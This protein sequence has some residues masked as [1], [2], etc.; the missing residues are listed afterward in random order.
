MFSYAHSHPQQG[1][2]L[3]HILCNMAKD[4]TSLKPQEWEAVNRMVFPIDDQ[5]SV[6]PLYMVRWTRPYISANLFAKQK[7]SANTPISIPAMESPAQLSVSDYSI[8]SKTSVTLSPS[9]HVSFCTYFNA[10]PASYWRRWTHVTTV[11]LSVKASG[12]GTISVCKSNAR[13][14]FSVIKTISYDDLDKQS[15]KTENVVV[16]DI[17][18]EN[19][20]D[21]GFLWIEAEAAPSETLSIHNAEWNVPEQ[22]HRISHQSLFSIAITTCNRPT[23]CLRQLKTIAR[24]AALR[25]HLDTIYCVDQG[26][27]CVDEQTGFKNVCDSL[28]HQLT[29]MHQANLGGSGGFSRG[30]YETV[31]ASRADYVVLLDDDAICEPESLLRAVQFANYTL[32]PYIVGGGMLHLDNR[33][34]L[35]TQGERF[36]TNSMMPAAPHG[37]SYNHDFAEMP[38]RDTPSLHQRANADFNGWWLCLIPT[39]VLQKIGLSMPFFLKYDDV[40]YGLRAKKHHINTISLPGV[41]V[42]HQAWHDKDISRTWEEYFAQR[43]RWICALL[44]TPNRKKQCAL[45]MFY[46]DAHLGVKLLYSGM[47][48]HHMALQD[49]LRGPSYLSDCLQSK[50]TE[51]QQ[52]RKDYPDSTVITDLLACPEAVRDY[53][54]TQQQPISTSKAVLSAIFSRNNGT[55]D[56]IAS[57]A[58]KAKDASWPAFTGVSSA[59]ITTNDGTSVVWARRN[60]RL[61]RHNLF[62][63]CNIVRKLVWKWKNLAAAYQQADLSSMAAWERYFND[64]R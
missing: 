63:C 32:Q 57:L 50:L 58:I 28:G 36:D 26:T 10:F 8:N 33:T 12:K 11:R 5:E 24:E 4:S 34:I 14:L 55:H 64:L 13:G 49:I 61:M 29:Y 9:I 59:L 2:K 20:L 27:D 51:V 40:E 35:Y 52:A 47:A 30:M 6:L 37:A 60:S 21:G 62:T 43:N 42:W 54:E 39:T 19:M 53:D 45:R 1:L 16:I 41:A 38:L 31:K 25:E 44:H 48:I 3:S 7:P 15:E 17:S 22:N 46:E 18:I 23:Y 56:R